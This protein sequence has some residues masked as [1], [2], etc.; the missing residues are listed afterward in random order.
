MFSF[1]DFD[2]KP[3]GLIGLT[4]KKDL[5]NFSGAM[6]KAA[7][8][9]FMDGYSQRIDLPTEDAEDLVIISGKGLRSET[10][11]ILQNAVLSVLCNEY[12]V[13]AKVDESNS[14]RI[15][16]EGAAL[17]DYVSRNNW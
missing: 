8:R 4:I 3:F 7:V 14:G 16:V 5:H 1:A 17:R 10:T 11:P 13:E 15:I 6:A 9:S 2:L 12:G